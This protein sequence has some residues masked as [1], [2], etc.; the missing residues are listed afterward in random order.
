MALE[1]LKESFVLGTRG[2][3]HGRRPCLVHTGGRHHGRLLGTR[4]KLH[5]RRPCLVHTGGRHHGRVFRIW[6]WFDE[7][8]PSLI[9]HATGGHDGGWHWFRWRFDRRCF[10]RL[11]LP[12]LRERFIR[13]WLLARRTTG[14]CIRRIQLQEKFGFGW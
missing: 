9:H 2:K 11:L 14:G 4:G 12:R 8:I 1:L 10:N 13:C 6:G 7:L 3:L 5:G